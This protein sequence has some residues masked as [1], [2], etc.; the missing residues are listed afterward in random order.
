MKMVG[1][2]GIRAW[3][4]HGHEGAAGRLAHRIE[5]AGLFQPARP[6]DRHDKSA[7]LLFAELEGEDVECTPSGVLAQGTSRLAIAPAAFMPATDA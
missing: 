4:E 6:L 3:A 5:E 2:G 1:V 7:L